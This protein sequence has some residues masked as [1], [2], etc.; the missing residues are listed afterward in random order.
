ME[1]SDFSNIQNGVFLSAKIYERC[2]FFQD[3]WISL[4]LSDHNFS[5]KF[6]FID[7]QLSLNDVNIMIVLTQKIVSCASM[8]SFITKLD[9]FVMLRCLGFLIPKKSI[10]MCRN[11][12]KE[13]QHEASWWYLKY[14][15]M[16]GEGNPPEFA[17]S[18]T[19]PTSCKPMQLKHKICWIFSLLWL[20]CVFVFTCSTTSYHAVRQR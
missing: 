20:V 14:T 11:Y 2:D 3:K 9:V 5:M 18:T 1:T 6:S 19:I 4:S 17:S 8:C 10:F 15:L 13:T 7:T 16:F 12:S